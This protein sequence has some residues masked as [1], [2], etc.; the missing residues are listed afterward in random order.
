MDKLQ[1]GDCASCDVSLVY[2][3]IV[4]DHKMQINRSTS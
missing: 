1:R 2:L 4:G 3:R